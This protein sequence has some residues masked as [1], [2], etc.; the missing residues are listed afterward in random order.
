MEKNDDS[1]KDLNNHKD[2]KSRDLSAAK[3]ENVTSVD[4]NSQLGEEILKELER[5]ENLQ[6]QKE[7]EQNLNKEEPS[8]NKR[9]ILESAQQKIFGTNTKEIIPEQENQPIPKEEQSQTTEA[10]EIEKATVV[11]N[12]ESKTIDPQIDA[13]YAEF[14]K[15]YERK[16]VNPIDTSAVGKYDSDLDFQLNRKIKKVRFP[17]PKGIKA[18]ICCLVLILVAVSGLMIALK[19]TDNTPPVVL[20]QVTLSQ[21]TNFL[22]KYVVNNVYVGDKLNCENIYINCEYTDD[23]IRKVELQRSMLSTTSQNINS[24][25]IFTQSGEVEFVVTYLNKTINLTYVV[26]EKMVESISLF[27]T[28]QSDEYDLLASGS[29]LDISQ[30]VV[31]NAHYIDGQ[32]NPIYTKRIDLSQCTYSIAGGSSEAIVANKINTTG[33]ISGNTYTVTISFEG[34]SATFTIKMQ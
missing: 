15:Q 33:L 4:A 6:K 27:T 25:D 14:L 18:L 9:I 13:K 7:S 19:F 10:V 11:E 30:S 28:S 22:D 8:V 32:N 31:V 23:S 34:H 26:E 20:K 12:E 17:M 1:I 3:N 21:P 29:T 5:L 16:K 24:Q 2:E